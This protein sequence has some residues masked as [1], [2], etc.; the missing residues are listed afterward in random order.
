MLKISLKFEAT[1]LLNERPPKIALLAQTRRD[2]VDAKVFDANTALELAP[3]Y[4]C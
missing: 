3:A 1:T 2:I 4:W